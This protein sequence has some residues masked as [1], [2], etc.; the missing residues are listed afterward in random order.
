MT[1]YC[2]WGRQQVKKLLRS[3]L[4]IEKEKLGLNGNQ[5]HDVL[6]NLSCINCLPLKLHITV[7]IIIVY[8][9]LGADY[10]FWF[11]I[12]YLCE[13]TLKDLP[14]LKQFI[15]VISSSMKS[16]R[17]VLKNELS[18]NPFKISLTVCNTRELELILLTV[19]KIWGTNFLFASY[20]S[21]ESS[22]T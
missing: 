18:W 1:D 20:F 22:R 13:V 10:K 15:S 19:S 6:C 11:C 2:S 12:M 9:H 5:T 7:I 21:F 8:S 4:A 17:I 14:Y 16:G 3:R